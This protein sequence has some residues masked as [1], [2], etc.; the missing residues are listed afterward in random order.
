M[1]TREFNKIIKSISIKK[2]LSKKL[3][4]NLSSE[5]KNNLVKHMV[6]TRT[7]IMDCLID[8]SDKDLVSWINCCGYGYNYEFNGIK[9]NGTCG[10]KITAE[11]AR[12][13]RNTIKG[14]DSIVI[15]N[16]LIDDLEMYLKDKNLL[17][18]FAKFRRSIGN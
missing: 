5:I 17:E 13:K 11:D 16:D 14:K 10:H 8:K 2:K 3:A 15:L 6:S 12:N 9:F 4:Q 7:P 18:D 1:K